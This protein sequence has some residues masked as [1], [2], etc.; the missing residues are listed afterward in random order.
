MLAPILITVYD[1]K[2]HLEKSIEA[3]KKNPLA[4][5][6]VLYIASDA[7]YSKKDEKKVKEI[8]EFIDNINGFKEIILFKSNENKGSYES[9][10]LAIEKILEKHDKIIFL[11]DDIIVSKY[12]LE[13][14]NNSLNLYEENNK[15]FAICSYVPPDFSLPKLKTEVYLWNY[16]CPWGMATWKKKWKELD[17]NLEKYMEFFK[18]KRQ[19][20][21]F[22]QGANHALPILID[23]RNGL[24]KAMDSRIDWN[25]FQKGLYCVFPI[26][27]LSKNIGVDGSGEHSG[28][29]KIYEEQILEDFNPNLI[30]NISFDDYVYKERKKYHKFKFLERGY[31]YF[32]IFNLHHILDKLYITNLM[33]KLRFILKFLKKKL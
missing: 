2:A 32:K 14:M 18:N 25:I 31:V 26:K 8:R 9:T 13:F 4:K 30:K 16:Y 10:K 33:K 24:I 1:R 5:E 28:K 17:L 12:F 6:S 23:D 27:T 29:N 3:L 7:A 20:I 15:I 22:F 11:E 19:V 21:K